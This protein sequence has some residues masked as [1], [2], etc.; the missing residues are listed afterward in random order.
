MA[1]DIRKRLEELERRLAPRYP[2]WVEENRRRREAYQEELEA[3]RAAYQALPTAG[4]IEHKRKELAEL[5]ANYEQSKAP[6]AEWPVSPHLWDISTSYIE[7]DILTLEGATRDFMSAARDWSQRR[8]WR[9]QS[10]KREE[11]EEARKQ[12]PRWH[13]GEMLSPPPAREPDAVIPAPRLSSGNRTRQAVRDY[14]EQQDRLESYRDQGN[15]PTE[16]DH[17]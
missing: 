11:I 12:W 9:H 17:T 7:L 1:R 15:Q 5:D 13:G 16:P 10:M 4:K 6:G 14:Q 2:A 3:D 8:F